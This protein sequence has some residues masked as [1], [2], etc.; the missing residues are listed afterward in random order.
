VVRL[1][2]ISALVVSF[3]K[4][5]GNDFI[6]ANPHGINQPRACYFKCEFVPNRRMVAACPRRKRAHEYPP[7]E[8]ND[9]K[10]SMRR[11]KM[12]PVT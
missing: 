9:V 11:L 4:H 2:V 12:T 8:S 10:R 1:D 5:L 6:P 7:R 3:R